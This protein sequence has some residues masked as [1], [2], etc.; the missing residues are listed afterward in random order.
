M[1]GTAGL[2]LAEYACFPYCRDREPA[3]LPGSYCIPWFESSASP[4]NFLQSHCY[5]HYTL[6][7]RR[8]Q[9]FV[10][11]STQSRMEDATEYPRRLS[12]ARTCFR[13]LNSDNKSERDPKRS[14][15]TE[16]EK[17]ISTSHN[18]YFSAF[19]RRLDRQ[20]EHCNFSNLLP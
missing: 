4:C 8:P 2:S 17:A 9:H 15:K 16:G 3:R 1:E 13:A 14:R 20:P 10:H 6:E 11:I 12:F 5:H 18:Y 19:T 7:P